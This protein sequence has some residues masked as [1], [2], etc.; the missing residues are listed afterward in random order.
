MLG[1]SNMRSVGDCEVLCPSQWPLVMH[2]QSNSLL[3]LIVLP[4]S[5]LL[6][7]L[8]SVLHWVASTVGSLPICHLS[9]LLSLCMAVNR[10]INC[11]RA[12]ASGHHSLHYALALISPAAL[13]W[14]LRTAL[15]CWLRTARPWFLRAALPWCLRAVWS[16]VPLREIWSLT[17]A[18]TWWI[19]AS[20]HI[21]SRM[22]FLVESG[23]PSCRP[24]TRSFADACCHLARLESFT[25]ELSC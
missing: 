4:P 16:S 25:E 9:V 13:P 12:N 24:E 6:P 1:K 3:G 15:P 22:R 5:V 23:D 14:S 7:V 17:P 2:G 19:C 10:S 21:L 11:L 18:V 20:L 8:L